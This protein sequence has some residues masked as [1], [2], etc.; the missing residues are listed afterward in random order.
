M[1][2][3][4]PTRS[5]KMLLKPVITGYTV[6]PDLTGKRAWQKG[7]LYR[8]QE[9]GFQLRSRGAITF[10][11]HLYLVGNEHATF[12]DQT[13]TSF[14]HVQWSIKARDAD[15]VVFNTGHHWHKLDAQFMQVSHH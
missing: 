10:A 9:E 12:W 1:T 13:N 3:S 11:H 5:L 2:P 6:D 14:E 7:P 8:K 4:L 15:F